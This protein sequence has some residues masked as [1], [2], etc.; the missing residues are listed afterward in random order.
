MLPKDLKSLVTELGPY[1]LVKNL[2]LHEFITADFINTFVKKG[3]CYALTYNTNIDE[4]NTVALLP[5]GKLILSL[6][7]DTYEEIGLQGRPSKYSGRKSMKFIVSVDLMELS[8]NMYSKKYKRTSWSFKEKKPLKFNFL[9]A[10]HNTGAAESSLLSYFSKYHIQEHQPSVTESRLGELPCPVL[11]SDE[12][13]GQPGVLCG[14]LELFEWLGAVCS[15]VG[16]NNEPHSFISTYCCPQPNTPLAKAYLCSITGFLLPEKICLLL[17]R[18]R[19]YFDEPKLTPWL[20]LSVHGFA[21]SPVSWKEKEHGFHKGGEHIYNFVI[22]NN[23]DYWLRMAIG[24][25]S[26]CPP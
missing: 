1:Y 3:S 9:F 5:N 19:H 14:A 16:Q 6:D 15:N 26:D 8:F 11:Q 12:M 17:E 10:W 24:V 18:L 21:D 22:F 23:Q 20:T 4:D 25:N 13:T 2:P 7:K